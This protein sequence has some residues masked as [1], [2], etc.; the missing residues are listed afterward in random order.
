MTVWLTMKW[1][2]L[3]GWGVFTV[4]VLPETVAT[5]TWVA[6]LPA[7]WAGSALVK[8]MFSVESAARAAA[9]GSI[10][11]AA[12][13]RKAVLARSRRDC[14]MGFLLYCAGRADYRT[15]HRPVQ[16]ITP[17]SWRDLRALRTKNPL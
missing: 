5:G 10:A 7:Q 6:S 14:I 3:I 2:S 15:G 12:A 4:R 9:A 11:A 13:P 16:A 1:A 8:M 17:P